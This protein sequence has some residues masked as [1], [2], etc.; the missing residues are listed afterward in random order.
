MLRFVIWLVTYNLI[1]ISRMGKKNEIVL[2]NSLCSPIHEC[3][4]KK[5]WIKKLLLKSDFR[6]KKRA[7]YFSSVRFHFMPAKIISVCISFNAKS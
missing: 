7:M 6:K 4:C 2:I 5:T 1:F 3:P